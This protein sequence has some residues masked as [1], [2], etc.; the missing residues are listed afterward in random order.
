MNSCYLLYNFAFNDIHAVIFALKYDEYSGTLQAFS[1]LTLLA[2][3]QEG[4][5]P[6]KNLSGARCRLAYAS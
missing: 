4:H 3:R 1:A 2:G 6:V 5:Q